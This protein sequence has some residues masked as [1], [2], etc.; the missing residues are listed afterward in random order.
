MS[1]SEEIR[2]L[3]PIYLPPEAQTD[4]FSQLEQF[5]DNIDARI[6]SG[7]LP[8]KGAIFQGDGFGRLLIVNLPDP[9]IGE[10]PGM[11]LSN[12][13]DISLENRRFTPPRFVYCPI[14]KFSRYVELVRR[15]KGIADEALAAHL[16]AVRKQRIS[17]ILFLPKGAGLSEDCIALLDRINNCD[18]GYMSEETVNT[19]RLFSFSNYGFYLFLVKLSIHFTRIREGINRQ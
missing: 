5:P 16:D 13:C 1:L 18:L 6:Y 8:D 19:T 7:V 15:F 3:L 10:G 11:I 9:K 14:L 2:R 4:L 12:S 17:S